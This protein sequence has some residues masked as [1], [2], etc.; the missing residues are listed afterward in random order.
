MEEKRD[1]WCEG[2][3]WYDGHRGGHIIAF[4][5]AAIFGFAMGGIIGFIIGRASC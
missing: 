5:V 2:R 1:K 3:R 4:G